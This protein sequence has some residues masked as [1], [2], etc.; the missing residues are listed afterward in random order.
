MGQKP[1]VF[2]K[3]GDVMRLGV[4]RLGEQQQ[5]VVADD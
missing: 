2:L 1:P 3:P 4:E 5:R